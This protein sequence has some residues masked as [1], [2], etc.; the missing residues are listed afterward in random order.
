MDERGEWALR[1][2]GHALSDK[3]SYNLWEWG[4]R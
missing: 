1:H 4:V 2:A 3:T